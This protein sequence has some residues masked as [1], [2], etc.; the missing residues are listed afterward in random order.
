MPGF[1]TCWEWVSARERSF[2]GRGC[3][4]SRGREIFHVGIRNCAIR[5]IPTIQFYLRYSHVLTRR[6]S[7]KISLWAIFA[8][9]LV[10][11]EW[12]YNVW[13]TWLCKWH[14]FN[15]SASH[16][17]LVIHV[18]RFF[19]LFCFVGFFSER[20]EKMIVGR[21]S[22]KWV[23]GAWDLVGVGIRVIYISTT[24]IHWGKDL[25]WCTLCFERNPKPATNGHPSIIP[26]VNGL[27]AAHC[28]C[29]RVAQW[30]K[31]ATIK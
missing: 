7:W 29:S 12:F 11:V 6:W 25:V 27:D 2:R 1:S 21:V 28:I 17:C 13:L 24:A 15:G 30:I 3:A 4:S 26:I 8:Q 23:A 10:M 5:S 20:R 18:P 14:N 16:R 22:V 19:V 9:I 31:R